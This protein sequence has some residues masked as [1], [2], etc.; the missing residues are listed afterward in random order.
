MARG[1]STISTMTGRC[2]TTAQRL[3]VSAGGLY[4]QF[5]A[6]CGALLLWRV[7]EPG[8]VVDLDHSTP[9][10][11][12]LPVG[13]LPTDVAVAPDGMMTFVAAAEV[14]KPAVYGVPSYRLLGDSQ[15]IH[16]F[17]TPAADALVKSRDV[18]GTNDRI[19]RMNP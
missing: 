2:S 17:H 15:G 14:N 16:P 3:W 1:S 4:Y 19:V 7:L 11:N 18:R 13:A 9:G 6:G 12:F 5:L 10:I 8:T